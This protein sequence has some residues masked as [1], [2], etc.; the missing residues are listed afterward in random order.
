MGGNR[1]E[2]TKQEEIN[3]GKVDEK[4]PNVC[5]RI[6]RSP[7]VLALRVSLAR[8][9][10][11]ARI[12]NKMRNRTEKR[13]TV[14]LTN[15]CQLPLCDCSSQPLLEHRVSNIELQ[16]G[17]PEERAMS[18]VNEDEGTHDPR[19]WCVNLIGSVRIESEAH[20]STQP[21]VA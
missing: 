8:N 11:K 21:L 15:D 13:G 19:K 7:R 20:C 10:N 16:F 18:R 14:E 6:S 9:A 1:Y 5:R 17:C 2:S 12:S 4:Y 3:P